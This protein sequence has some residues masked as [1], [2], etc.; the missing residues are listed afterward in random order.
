[1]HL[2]II[3]KLQQ[4][5]IC[6]KLQLSLY[7]LIKKLLLNCFSIKFRKLLFICFIFFFC[8]SICIIDDGASRRRARNTRFRARRAD[9]STTSMCLFVLFFYKRSICIIDNGVSRRR[10]RNARFRA[11]RADHSTT[12]YKQKLILLKAWLFCFRLFLKMFLN[13]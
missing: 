7:G 6:E 8:R 1:M 10:T 9:H 11:R 5:H 12:D 2:E 3:N 4:D 13:L